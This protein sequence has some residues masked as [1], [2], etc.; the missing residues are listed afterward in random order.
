MVSKAAEIAAA[1]ANRSQVVS[2]WETTGF[3]DL[4]EKK[5]VEIV[6]NF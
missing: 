4:L 2:F 3:V 6:G 1:V 5:V